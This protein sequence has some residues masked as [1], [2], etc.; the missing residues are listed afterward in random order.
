MFTLPKNACIRKD[1]NS[2]VDAITTTTTYT[3]IAE[4]LQKGWD[5]LKHKFDSQPKLVKNASLFND[6]KVL[7]KNVARGLVNKKPTRTR[8]DY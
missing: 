1:C 7:K 3:C 8:K 6:I 4:Y 2:D 5:I